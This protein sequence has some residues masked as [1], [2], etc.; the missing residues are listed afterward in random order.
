[1]GGLGDG[2]G[3]CWTVWFYMILDTLTMVLPFGH[4][5]TMEIQRG[6]NGSDPHGSW[7][8]KGWVSING[9]TQNGWF[10]MENP[11]KMAPNGGVLPL[12]DRS[13]PGSSSLRHRELTTWIWWLIITLP[14]KMTILG[15]HLSRYSPLLD[16]ICDVGSTSHLS[17]ESSESQHR[18]WRDVPLKTQFIDT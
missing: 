15:V 3:W 16:P 14:L 5:R 10:I 17:S 4:F 7:C 2:R 8:I 13:W 1:M 18:K 9:G 6:S 11:F 12:Q